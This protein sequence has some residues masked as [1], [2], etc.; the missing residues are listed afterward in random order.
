MSS[1]VQPRTRSHRRRSASAV[2]LLLVNPRFPESFWSFRWALERILFD[3]RALNPPLGL[4]TLA[5]LCPPDWQVE[6][7]D[8]NI[9]PLPPSPQADIIGI[10]GMAVQFVR[11]QELLRFYRERGYYVVAG[12][13][14]AS[15]CP[16][17]YADLADTVIA[18]E[19]EYVWPRFC[20]DFGAGRTQPL[21][22]EQGVVDLA[23]SPAPRFDL[24]RMERYVTASLQF[25]RGCPYRCEFCDIIVM[26]GRRPRT[27]D[28]L[29]VG[30][31]L[32][33]LRQL[34]VRSVFFVDDNLIGNRPKAK[35]LLRYLAD[36]QR[37]HDYPFE[38]GTEAS[39]NLAE[40]QELLRLF[41]EAGF[42]WVFIGIESPDE[43]SLVE[44]RKTQNTRLDMLT[45]VRRIYRYGIDVLAGFIVGFDSDGPE[46]FE[47]Q[48]RFIQEAGIQ[49]AMVGLLNALPKTPLYERLAR[50][51]R[52]IEGVDASDNTK[53]GT[54]FIPQGMSYEALV[55]GYKQL[56]RR[57]ASD[58]AIAERI[59][60]KMRYLCRPL[61]QTRHRSSERL[62]MLG[63]FL[64]RGVVAGGTQRL[65]HFGRSLASARLPVWSLIVSDWIAALAMRS[66]V[67][68]YF[69][70]DPEREHRL[71]QD[72][73][74]FAR[75]V[76]ARSLRLGDLQLAAGVP[77]T[78]M[79]LKITLRGRIDPRFYTGVARRLE[80]LLRR[81]AA[82]VSLKVET[83]SE[84]QLCLIDR[85]LHRLARYGDRVV[86][87]LH[88]H[89]RPRLTVDLSLFRTEAA[90]VG[91]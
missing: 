85:L 3:R 24:L 19:A 39:L 71:L 59:V 1:V 26:F 72:T 62:G 64:I 90:S 16:E 20:R 4:A 29:Q 25:S 22:H 47:R 34:G 32:E 61:P 77:Q 38:F 78:V 49:V 9:E 74:A 10:C 56:Y 65:W 68:H 91:A 23:D 43:A 5:A 21:Y 41:R 51:G 50:A 35:A 55:A 67:H 27:K 28:P 87:H 66:Y 46:I 79:R 86:L 52:L 48:Y 81:S 42:A 17:R 6:I 13:S 69:G 75:R 14:Y 30:R 89:V 40:D 57:L 54:N 76:C 73:L 15:L 84:Q 53:P 70:L 83:I 88:P 12:G 31:E 58:H 45:A 37:R 7:V 44:A 80:R 11:Q 63:R 18:G 60:N 36:Y 8:E 33:A 2:R 82:M